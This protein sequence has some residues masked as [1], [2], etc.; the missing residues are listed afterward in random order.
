LRIYPYGLNQNR[1][2]Q[3][4]RHLNLPVTL[5]NDLREAEVLFTLRTYYRKRPQAIADAERRGIPVYV[6][7]NNTVAQIESYLAE[8]F[9]LTRES[10]ALR[11][12]LEEAREAIEEVMGGVH[13]TAQLAPQEAYI[14]RMQHE[15]AREANLFSRSSGSDPHRS[16]T[17]Y[18]SH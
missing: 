10:D 4:S 13:E 5:V 15:L 18:G 9:G 2:R 3:A 12:A 14:R 17:I 6:L 11:A 16:V 1:V 7:R 8:I